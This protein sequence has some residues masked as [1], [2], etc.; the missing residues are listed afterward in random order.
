[1]R[2]LVGVEERASRFGKWFVVDPGRPGL[3]IATGRLG[4][5]LVIN[6]LLSDLIAKYHIPCS[7]VQ[8]LLASVTWLC[9]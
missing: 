5:S 1:M 6:L 4:L 7:S 3:R 8:L 9:V 2:F